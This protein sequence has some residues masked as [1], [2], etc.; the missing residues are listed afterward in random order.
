MADL[1]ALSMSAD[2]I[3]QLPDAAQRTLDAYKHITVDNVT[4][5]CTY[6]INA[7]LSSTTRALVGKGAPQEIER[8]ARKWFEKYDMHANGDPET[9][10]SLLSACG[11]GVDCSGFVSWILNDITQATLGRPVWKCLQFPGLR[12]RAISKI[13]P[14]ENISANLLTGSLNSRSVEDLSQIKPGDLIR[15]AGWH[16]VLIITEV[17]L[18][19]NG[20]A[21]YFQY[22]QSSCLY[23]QASGIRQGYAVIRKPKSSLVEQLWFDNYD[24]DVIKELIADGSDSR[25]V[26]LKALSAT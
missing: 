4:A 19:R 6:H 25:V 17:G 5:P 10:R 21:T 11:I 22:A 1:K 14:V 16:H 26:R 12:R 20:K 8:I 18:N 13:R 9:L 15:A 3:L 24:K 23:G 2:R 7:G